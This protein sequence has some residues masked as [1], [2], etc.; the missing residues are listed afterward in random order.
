MTHLQ[1]KQSSNQIIFKSNNL[2]IKQSSNQTILKSNNLQ[3]KQSS[4]QTILKSNNPQI[5]QSSNQII[6]KSYHLQISNHK[7]LLPPP[8]DIFRCFLGKWLHCFHQNV[9]DVHI[10]SSI[11]FALQDCQPKGKRVLLL[12]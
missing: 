1:I 2:Q 8:T 11:Q 5:K 3:I 12:S 10:Y 6:F 7:K 9:G 4:N